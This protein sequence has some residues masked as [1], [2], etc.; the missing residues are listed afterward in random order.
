VLLD[1]E[2]ER[3]VVT[4]FLDAVADRPSL[5]ELDGPPGSGKTTLWRYVV[6]EARSRSFRVLSS[7][8]T[9]AE[10]DLPFV[11]LTDL[12]EPVLE[13]ILPALAE[14]E[15]RALAVVMLLAEP[16]ERPPDLRAVSMAVLHGLRVLARSVPLV[17]AVDDEACLDRSSQRVLAYVVRRLVEERIGVLTVVRGTGPSIL[18]AQRSDPGAGRRLTLGPLAVDSTSE[19]LHREVDPRLPAPLI[20]ELHD[21]A[22]GNPLFALEIA[23]AVV[24]EGASSRPGNPLAV[25]PTLRELLRDRLASL[26]P[27]AR[28]IVVLVGSMR[29]PT[30]GEVCAAAEDQELADVG[31]GQAVEAGVVE[32]AEGRLRLLNPVLGSILYEDLTPEARRGLHGRVAQAV[33]D[34]D[35]RARHRALSVEGPDPAVAID[36]DVAADRCFRRG[37]PDAAARLQELALDRTPADDLAGRRARAV[38]AGEWHFLAGE[39]ARTDTLFR[40]ALDASP[41]GPLRADALRRLGWLAYHQGASEEA[42]DLFARALDEAG[43]D[44]GLRAVIERDLAFAGL[45][46]GDLEEAARHARAALDLAERLGDDEGLAEAL[47]AVGLSE[48]V[49]GRAIRSDVLQRAVDLEEWAAARR[50]SPRPSRTPGLLLSWTEDLEA[51]R[52]RLETLLDRTLE[53]GDESSV[54]IVLHHLSDL[55]LRAGN[56]A[57]AA[58]HARRGYE[59]AVTT[60]QRPI[61][62]LLLY[63]R[64]AVSAHRGQVED[65]RS[66]ATDGA[67]LA[68]GIDATIARLMN[69]SVL[70]FLELSL[71]NPA[72]AHRELGPVVEQI[73]AMRLAE[74]T[75]ISM[76]PDEIAALTALGDLEAAESLVSE[77]ERRGRSV[78]REWAAAV[79]AR[80]RGVLASVRGDAVTAVVLIERAMTH[81]RKLA[82]PFELGRTMLSLGAVQRRAR[83]KAPARESLQRALDLFSELGARLWIDLTRAQLDRAGFRPAGPFDL[84]ETEEQIADLVSKGMTNVE[85]AKALFVSDR[86][87]EANLSRIYRKLGVRSR[88]ELAVAWADR[89]AMD[90]GRREG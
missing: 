76:I 44:D 38:R 33:S 3:E 18:Q 75:V 86:T 41:T 5:L 4:A 77:L 83:Q 9:E 21:Q 78:R 50:A 74:P 70:G 30:P 55:E 35:E 67:A 57:L 28:E 51:G 71:G 73:I 65:A 42:A 47:T 14:P 68:D 82:E 58:E 15:R 72:E 11:A 80:A 60:G 39:P 88:T 27:P 45:R 66:L 32:S 12:L 36:L 89:S 48:A 26:T 62:S 79:T 22:G 90:A 31:L 87:I 2:A 1:R 16:E 6:G 54:P 61:E 63:S 64:A 56:W 37:A 24:A 13:Q 19:L 81:H 84:T 43:E 17:L 7:Q 23:R 20:R 85:A 8:P 10:R 40:E 52:T 46:Y 59:A 25:P 53:R 69:R 34:P 49:L 29:R